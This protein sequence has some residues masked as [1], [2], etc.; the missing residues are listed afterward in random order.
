MSA[1][2]QVV[3]VTSSPHKHQ[4]AQAILGFPLA[5]ASLDLLEPQTL[6]LLRVTRAKAQLAYAQLQRP[7]L[8]EDTSLELRALGGFPGP[9]VRWLLEAAGAA[10]LA[11][12]VDGFAD[13][14]AAARCIALLYDG[15]REWVGRGS[16][17]GVILDSPRGA[18][19]F[20]W[21]SVFAP[22]WGGGRSFAEMTSEE[23]NARSHRGL[24]FR[25]LRRSLQET[26][27]TPEP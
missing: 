20:G 14:H 15:A 3:F 23:K 16:V 25:D 7:V 26:G 11:R 22:H 6:D 10:A 27:A 17:D 8:V 19:G 1:L 2:S 9:F 5:R 12:M 18:S 4:E 13:R 24:A 21:D